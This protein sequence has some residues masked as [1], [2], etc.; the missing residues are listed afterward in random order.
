MAAGEIE[1]LGLAAHSDAL[2]ARLEALGGLS[3]AVRSSG[4]VGTREYSGTV[5]GKAEC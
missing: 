4:G 3:A 2:W 1:R 5:G